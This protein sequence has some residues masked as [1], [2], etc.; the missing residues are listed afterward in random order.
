MPTDNSTVMAGDMFRSKSA[1]HVS[2][3]QGGS[4]GRE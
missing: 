1:T 4:P 2:D 3:Y